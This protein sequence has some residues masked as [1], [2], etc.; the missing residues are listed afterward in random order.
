MLILIGTVPTAYALNR[1]MPDSQ[2][3]QFIANSQRRERGDR[4]QAAGY[5]V[6]GNPRPAVTSYVATREINDGHLSRA[7]RAGRARS[8]KQVSE[9]GSLAQVPGRDAVGNAR[10]DMYLASEA[11]RA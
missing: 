5:N 8:R 6:L 4:R 2:I 1:S 10:N 3:A 9:Y 7:G 11:L